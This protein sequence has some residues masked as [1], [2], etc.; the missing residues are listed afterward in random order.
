MS[1]QGAQI[2]MMIVDELHNERH[3]AEMLKA[4]E[5]TD[6]RVVALDLQKLALDL[7]KLARERNIVQNKSFA[8]LYGITEFS[9]DIK[10]KKK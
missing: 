7:Q 8:A 2:T 5:T 1:I 6:L 10:E 9:E 4:L 3:V